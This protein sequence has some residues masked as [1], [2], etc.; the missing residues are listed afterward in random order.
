LARRG[1]DLGLLARTRTQLEEVAAEVRALGARAEVLPATVDDAGSVH[2]AFSRLDAAYGRLDALVN[3]AGTGSFAPVTEADPDEW[4]R[5]ISVNLFGTFLCS[6]EAARRMTAQ[7]S[8]HIVNVLSIAAK[9]VFPGASAYCASKWGA[10]GLTKALAEETRGQGVKVT[11]LCPG[12]IDTPF[13]DATVT[14]LD[15]RDMLRPEDVAATVR[16]LLE[17]PPGIYTDEMVVMPPKGIL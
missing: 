4:Q 14:T 3:C 5:I 13:W 8:G 17:Q 1:W 16:M 11:G 7:G 12:S 9:V 15:R 6:R 2:E 10:L